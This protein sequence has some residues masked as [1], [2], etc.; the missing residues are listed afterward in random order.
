MPD[1]TAFSEHDW[2]DHKNLVLVWYNRF[3]CVCATARLSD[4]EGQT[5]GRYI[6]CKF[7]PTAQ[8]A[9]E[10]ERKM[11]ESHHIANA[12]AQCTSPTA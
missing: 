1:S 11:G 10:L 6:V 12:V 8:T 3:P 5:Y 7:G 4:L 2:A 9:H